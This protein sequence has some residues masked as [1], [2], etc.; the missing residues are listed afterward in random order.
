MTLLAWSPSCSMNS[1]ISPQHMPRSMSRR[2]VAQ[3]TLIQLLKILYLVITWAGLISSPAKASYKHQRNPSLPRPSRSLHQIKSLSP[4][5]PSRHFPTSLHHHQLLYPRLDPP[6]RN[7][8]YLPKNGSKSRAQGVAIRNRQAAQDSRDKKRKFLDDLEASN[9][10]LTRRNHY[11]NDRLE[12]VEQ[13]NSALKAENQSLVAQL[14]SLNKR[15]KLLESNPNLLLG[16]LSSDPAAVASQQRILSKWKTLESKTRPIVDLKDSSTSTQAQHHPVAA[17]IVLMHVLHSMIYLI[18]NSGL[19]SPLISRSTTLQS[20]SENLISNQH[21]ST[22][23]KV[24]PLHTVREAMLSSHPSLSS[25]L[26]LL[27]LHNSHKQCASSPPR[28]A[29]F[30]HFPV[31]R[32]VWAGL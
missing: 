29:R 13:A 32:T 18:S 12:S 2:R 23:K 30:E 19:I 26:G 31:L 20:K 28:Q 1:P 14:A 15:F 9:D 22:P 6:E 27:S 10:H 21:V 16:A 4:R 8:N 3:Q 5:Y 25:R 7:R 24:E 17:T 11:L